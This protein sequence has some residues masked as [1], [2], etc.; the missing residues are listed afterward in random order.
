MSEYSEYF[1]AS[2]SSV[3]MLETVELSHPNWSQVYR[4][5]RNAVDGITATTEAGAQ[6]F[7][8]Y[9]LRIDYGGDRDD[10]DQVFTISLGDL[11]E[12]LPAEL[13]AVQAAGGFATPP[14]MIYRAWRS[15]DLATMI[16][17]P[18]SLRVES[19][20]FDRAGATFICRAQ[21]LNSNRTGE[22]YTLD[23]F[24]MLRGFL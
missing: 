14:T 9:P 21:G 12:I 2:K 20:T 18:V 17:G 3:V 11:G 6:A 23:R 13:D 22:L 5:V 16:Y 24:P 7:T 15:D 4:I 19:F 1:L 8:Y 10:L